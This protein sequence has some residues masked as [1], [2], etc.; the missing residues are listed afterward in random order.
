[1]R[2]AWAR[3]S[4][5]LP[6]LLISPRRRIFGVHSLSLPQSPLFT[7]GRPSLSALRLT[8]RWV[9]PSAAKLLFS[10]T[11]AA[12]LRHQQVVALLPLFLSLYLSC[13]LIFPL[14]FPLFF[15][16]LLVSS[17]SVLSFPIS[18]FFSLFLS[19]THKLTNTPR[20]KFFFLWVYLQQVLPYWCSGSDRKI[21]RQFWNS[22]HL[23][24]R[25]ANFHVLITT[26]TLA[27]TD[28]KYLQRLQVEPNG[29]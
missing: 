5:A 4:K 9:K 2:W 26:Y 19:H 28:E 15:L 16:S 27:V 24:T 25:H 8:S 14:S 10:D 29:G 13:P 1:M 12:I 23:S 22:K 7:T 18:F 6:R 11:K 3:R 17:L 21:L 20:T